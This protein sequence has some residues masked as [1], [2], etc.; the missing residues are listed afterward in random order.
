MVQ[1]N[2]L[3]SVLLELAEIKE[4]LSQAKETIQSLKKENKQLKEII[5]KDSS[6][7]SKPP[8]TNNGL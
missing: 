3:K 2:L 1:D 5:N 4:E 8:S 7:S 6:N